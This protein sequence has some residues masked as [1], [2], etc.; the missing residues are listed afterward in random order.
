[1]SLK[2]CVALQVIM[3]EVPE[4]EPEYLEWKAE[5]QNRGNK[6][7]PEEFTKGKT[8]YEAEDGEGAAQQWQPAP[9]ETEADVAMDT[10]SLRRRLDQR[11]FLLVKTKGLT[12][13]SVFQEMLHR[14]VAVTCW[15]NKC[16]AT[17]SLIEPRDHGRMLYACKSRLH[18]HACFKLIL[19]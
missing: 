14:F 3:P 19:R 9:R 11:L 6:E 15:H 13:T 8:T 16:A 10:K 18:T 7:L 5:L 2:W 4:W 1:M 12:Q 17:V